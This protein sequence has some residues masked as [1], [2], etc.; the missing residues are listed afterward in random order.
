MTAHER[1]VHWLTKRVEGTDAAYRRD[2][3]LTTR[4]LCREASGSSL[5]ALLERI[6]GEAVE[7]AGGSLHDDIAL[8]ALR[9]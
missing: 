1:A 7:R 3:A 4:E 8:L 6:E 2:V 5:E 9:L